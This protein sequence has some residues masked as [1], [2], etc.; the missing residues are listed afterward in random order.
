MNK[1]DQEQQ[2]NEE[3]QTIQGDAVQDVQERENYVE[4]EDS[5]LEDLENQDT[6]LEE[7]A[8]K[9]PMVDDMQQRHGE[10]RTQWLNRI[11]PKPQVEKVE[12]K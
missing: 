1:E 2:M 7:T 8:K 9:A 5:K 11:N 12:K 6:R 3:E 4:L 10:N